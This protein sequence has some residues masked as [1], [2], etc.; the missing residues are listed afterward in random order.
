VTGRRHDYPDGYGPLAYCRACGCDFSGDT[1]FD[2]HRVGKHEY[3]WSP[4]RE[5]GRRCLD[6]EE[7]LERGWRPLTDEEM[8]SSRR[9]RH[10]VGF[11]VELWTDPVAGDRLRRE[12]ACGRAS[13][14][15]EALGALRIGE[16]PSR[17]EQL[18]LE[19]AS[20]P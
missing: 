9:H 19:E 12:M 7:M 3:D 8:R 6:R 10:R 17:L 20:A 15:A 1:L 14:A 4:E 13:G 2:L 5:D 11:G 18:R 16:T